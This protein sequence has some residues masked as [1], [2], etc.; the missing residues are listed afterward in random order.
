[1]EPIRIGSRRE[2]MWDD[3]LIDTDLTDTPLK[4]HHPTERESVVFTEPWAQGV[5]NAYMCVLR[6]GGRYLM[7]TN[8]RGGLV[9]SLSTDGI[10][11][12]RPDLG[13]AEYEGWIY[14][15]AK[16]SGKTARGFLPPS[17]LGLE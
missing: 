4:L 17:A 2:P 8:G 7:Y 15:E 11:W 14:V 16:V 9:C 13:L 12:E 5:N 1:M 6:D 3:Y 10:R